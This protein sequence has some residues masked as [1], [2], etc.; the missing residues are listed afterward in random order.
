MDLIKLNILKAKSIGKNK[1]W[2]LCEGNLYDYLTSLK[3]DFYEYAIQ[4]KIVRNDYLDQL[5]KTVENGEPFPVITLTTQFNH[6]IKQG[7]NIEFDPL[8]V[9]ILDGLQRT[10]RLW[11]HIKLFEAYNKS[12]NQGHGKT[13]EFI[14]EFK[15]SDDGGLFF[16]FGVF[17]SSYIRKLIEE[18]RIKS[19]KDV[20]EKFEVY[21]YV[22]LNLEE[23]EIVNK[24]LLLNLGQK[25]VSPK[26]QFELLFLNFYKRF[27]NHDSKVKI[28]R[29]RETVAKTL[30]GENREPGNFLFS[31]VIISMLSF[32]EGK[33]KRVN[34]ND[35]GFSIESEDDFDAPIF[36]I[37]FNKDFILNFLNSL[38]DIDNQFK[39]S[40]AGKGIKWFGK[41]T[42]LS[43]VFAGISDYLEVSNILADIDNDLSDSQFEEI[44]E[45]LLK[46]T[47]KGKN[48]FI[49][50]VKNGNI[51]LEGFEKAYENLSSR[52]IN[53]GNVVRTG[54]KEYVCDM[55]NEEQANWSNYI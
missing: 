23:I 51:D 2:L 15:S 30:R 21:F 47:N 35:L 3:T 29:E 25:S 14:R 12:K 32:Y 48:Q 43:G 53:I 38:Y 41:D 37:L 11:A 54:V 45:N 19:I 55:L 17:K 34:K 26:H 40:Y 39:K 4:R 10:F 36:K 18:N 24:M 13:L 28:I 52:S 20:C 1:H 22:W 50:N 46:L 44:R 27:N 8:K 33:A 16:E 42:T 9:E 49:K 6:K 31:S 5:F 7:E